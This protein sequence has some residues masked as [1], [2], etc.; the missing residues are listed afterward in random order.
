LRQQLEALRLARSFDDFDGPFAVILQSAPE[1]FACIT[2]IREDVAQPWEAIT[3]R[4]EQIGR[5]V[6]VLYISSVNGH[7]KHQSKRVSDNVA[8][9]PFD[10]LASIKA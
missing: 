3:D 7:K 10:L 1:F 6:S 2:A 5:A 9:A 8:L 4:P